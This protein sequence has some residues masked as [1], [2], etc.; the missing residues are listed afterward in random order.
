VAHL[1]NNAFNRR[2][3]HDR[4]EYLPCSIGRAVQ[5]LQALHQGSALRE[6]LHQR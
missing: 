3:T 6:L 5:A 4:N 1:A 2:E